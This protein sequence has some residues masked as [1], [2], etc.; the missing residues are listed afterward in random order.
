MNQMA[1]ETFTPFPGISAQVYSRTDFEAVREIVYDIAG[2]VLP[3]GKATLVYS[4]LAP[5]VRESGQQTFA[6]Y[7][8]LIR[9]DDGERRKTVN[10]LTTNHTFFYREAHHFEHLADVVRPAL[11]AKVK[12]GHPVRIWSAGCSTGEELYSL[13]MTLL[14][15][16][17]SAARVLLNGDVVILATDLAD[18]AVAGAKTARYAFE[19]LKDVPEPLVGAWVKQVGKEAHMAPEMCGMIRVKRLNLLGEWPM[20]RQFDVIFCRNVM[21]YFDQPTKERLVARFADQLLPGGHLYIGHSERVSGPAQD[22][23]SLV[24][25]TIYRK[26]RT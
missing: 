18:H 4:R 24:G 20:K 11:L 7:I 6:R 5:L 12:A 15:P 8:D 10:A 23:L 9:K 13:A 3:P 16:D 21:I 25:G 17:K 22:I 26:D 14:G 19:T 1:A 2:I